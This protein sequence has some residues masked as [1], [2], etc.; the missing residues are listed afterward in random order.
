MFSVYSNLPYTTMNHLNPHST[1]NPQLTQYLLNN[2]MADFTQGDQIDNL[3][4]RYNSY[5]HPNNNSSLNNPYPPNYYWIKD[6]LAKQQSCIH[7]A[8][9]QLIEGKG[10]K[11][12]ITHP[13]LI[14]DNQSL[15]KPN[16]SNTNN[17]LN[18][19]NNEDNHL[20]QNTTN[21]Y[22][23]NS[24]AYLNPDHPFSE[25]IQ[26]YS[27]FDSIVFKQCFP[28]KNFSPYTQLLLMCD[29]L[30]NIRE[31]LELQLESNGLLSINLLALQDIYQLLGSLTINSQSPVFKKA[32]SQ[33]HH[34]TGYTDNFRAYSHYIS[35][36]FQQYSRLL[37]IRIDLGYQ[38]QHITNY[39]TFRA[40]IDYFIKLI[41]SN[42]VFKDLIGYIWKL[43]YGT[44]K[45]Y[46]AHL[47]LCYD[48]AKRRS[49]YHIAKQI[50]ELWQHDITLGRGIYF[51]CNAKEQKES[52]KHCYLGMVH[53]SETDKINWM[54]EYGV[55]YLLKTD[56]YLR[57]MKP[58][59]RRI[60]GRGVIKV[61]NK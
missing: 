15:N 28:D 43:E 57:L 33:Y 42:P 37:I 56:E 26:A 58:D 16:D 29:V 55:S 13:T 6:R 3:D 22:M 23:S 41:P 44:D 39:E 45:G 54:I 51:N 30:I 59:N 1:I 4:H 18:N 36:L 21:P 20:N 10:D 60:L 47:L 48:G 2:G 32:L 34:D 46:H 7:S 25:L 38:Q 9:K 8:V 49:D 50:G 14:P 53:R 12:L 24:R 40:D 52:Y 11:I 31:Q 61:K 19:K 27:T 5:D 35:N 17:N